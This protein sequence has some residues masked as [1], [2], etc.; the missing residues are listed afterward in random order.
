VKYGLQVHHQSQNASQTFSAVL[1][2]CCQQSANEVEQ[3][4]KTYLI[5]LHTFLFLS[6]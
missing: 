6:Q 3:N 2:S 4:I 5:H 1:Q